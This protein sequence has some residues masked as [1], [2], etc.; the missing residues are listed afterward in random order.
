MN[1]HLQFIIAVAVI[2][3]ATPDAVASDDQRSILKN[4]P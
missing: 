2:F 4:C 3:F 1:K